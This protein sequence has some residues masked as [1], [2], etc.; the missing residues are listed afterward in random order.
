MVVVLAVQRWRPYLLGTKFVVKTDQKSLKFLL[1]H[2]TIQS[3]YK[4]WVAKLLGYSFEVVYKSGLENKAVDALSRKPMEVLN[5]G[6]SAPILVDLTTIKEEVEKDEKLQK[7]IAEEKA[8]GSRKRTKF[9]EKNGMWHYKN[10]LVLSKTST[11]IPAMLS[12]YHDSVVGGHSGFLHTYK[13]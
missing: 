12:T 3:Q 9:T 10:R 5:F 1:E 8:D 13:S 7:V 2:R 6:I 4:K 11:L